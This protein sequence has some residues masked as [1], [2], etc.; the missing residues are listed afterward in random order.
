[1]RAR[2]SLFFVCLCFHQKEKSSKV[3]FR[4]EGSS[5]RCFEGAQIGRLGCCVKENI[6]MKLRMMVLVLMVVLILMAMGDGGLELELVLMSFFVL[7][8]LL[9]VSPLF[10]RSIWCLSWNGGLTICS[11]QKDAI[12]EMD[13]GSQ[14]S[15]VFFFFE[16]DVFFETNASVFDF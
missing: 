13:F 1:M 6:L 12:H 3:V 5:H 9:F 8:F 7:L 10:I 2:Q 15:G 14:R 11:Q 16:E 4:S